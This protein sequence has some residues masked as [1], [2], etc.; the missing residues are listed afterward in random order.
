MS[1]Q[2]KR[3]YDAY[4]YH[5]VT[6]DYDCGYTGYIDEEGFQQVTGEWESGQDAILVLQFEDESLIILPENGDLVSRWVKSSRVSDGWVSG[7]NFI[8]EW[9]ESI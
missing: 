1:F 7:D 5:R 6:L 4:T 8:M 3:W 9:V 2:L